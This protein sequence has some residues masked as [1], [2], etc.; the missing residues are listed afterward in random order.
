M[1]D[2]NALPQT[3]NILRDKATNPQEYY[4][5]K[6]NRL[7][8][9]KISIFSIHLRIYFREEKE[10][11]FLLFDRNVEEGALFNIFA[12]PKIYMK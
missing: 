11:I 1:I 9:R 2:E 12:L 3:V 7:L 4:I 8:S 5:T 10:N 6:K